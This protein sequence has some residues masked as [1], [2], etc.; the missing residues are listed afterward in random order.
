M[1]RAGFHKVRAAAGEA[2][3]RWDTEG[4]LDFF[5]RFDEA[6]LF[7]DLEP[8]ERD[9]IVGRMRERLRQLDDDAFVLRLPVVYVL[10]RAGPA[11]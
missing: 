7:D 4:Y 10:G 1:R 3:H 8:A 5:T 9:D 6:A 11:G 2:V